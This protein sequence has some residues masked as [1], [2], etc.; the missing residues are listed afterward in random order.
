[1]LRS[2]V[3]GVA[4]Y[5]VTFSCDAWKKICLSPSSTF[6]SLQQAVDSIAGVMGGRRPLGEDART[7]LCAQSSGLLISYQRDDATRT[8]TIVDFLPVSLER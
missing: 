6:Q 2:G 5:R 3:R 8:V 4:P 1:M 7:E